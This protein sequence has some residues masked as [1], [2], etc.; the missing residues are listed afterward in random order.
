MDTLNDTM[1]SAAFAEEAQQPL[2]EVQDLRTYFHTDSGVV[3]AVDGVSFSVSAG[4]IVGIVGESG[5]GKSVTAM[6]IVR[7]IEG[8]ARIAGGKVLF[9]GRDVLKMS[10]EELRQLRG[11]DVAIVFQDPMSSLNPVL[12]I[13][14]QL[15]EAMTVHGRSEA[16]AARSA[17]SLLRSMGITAPE[18]AVTCYPHQFSGGMRQRVVIAMGLSNQPA[19]LLADEPTTALDVTVQAQILELLKDLNRDYG[20]AVVLISHNLG[21][22][23]GVCSRVVVMYAGE[24]VEEGPT[25]E[26]LSN[27]RHPYTWALMN[28]SPRVGAMGNHR[29]SSIEGMPPDPL[30]QPKGCRFAPRCPFRTPQCDE[31]PPLFQMQ[32]GHTSRCW[33]AHDGG[34]FVRSTAVASVAD[35]EEASPTVADRGVPLLEAENLVQHFPLRG[36]AFAK[37]SVVHAVDGVSLK[38]WPG[39]VVGLVGESGCGKSTLGS[40]LLRLLKPTGGRIVFDGHDITHALPSELRPL[41]RRMQMVFQN[42]YAS[43]N[44]RMTIGR[45]LG[46]PLQFHQVTQG[47]AQTRDRVRQ[48]LDLVGLGARA[49]DRYPHEFSGGQRQRVAIARAIALEPDFIVADEPISAL[50]VNIQAQIINLMAD[51]RERFRLTYLFISHDL[52]VVHHIS[53][54]IIV[55]HLGRIVEVASP[56]ELFASPL[57]PYTRFLISAIPVPDVQIERERQRLVLAGEAASAVAPP[58]G[59]PFRTRCPIAKAVCAEVEPPLVERQPGHF[60]ACH[61]PG[62]F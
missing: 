24:I 35:E 11:G 29:L 60:V 61:F 40:T 56:G 3:R 8:Q 52:A 19:L 44:P 16:D 25:E 15:S 20:T 34:K 30:N 39:E 47:D 17:V 23:A 50:D 32:P 57:H 28:A 2:L 18:R 55:L 13:E 1:A 14:Q 21:V 62:E 54:R 12:R 49:I 5:S 22:I 33:V 4:E 38:I 6:S 53:D 51:L 37:R 26:V 7:L 42:P 27:P 31:H 58:S 46:E 43:L 41:R 48:L 10:A 45:T 59:C 36:H 9:R